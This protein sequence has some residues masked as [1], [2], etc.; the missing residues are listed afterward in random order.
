MRTPGTRTCGGCRFWSEMI[1]MVQDGEVVAMCL[2][3]GLMASRYTTQRQTCDAFAE[4]MH[5]AI[6]APPDH[7]EK[8]RATYEK[9]IRMN[10]S[11]LTRDDVELYADRLRPPHLA[12]LRVAFET[13]DDVSYQKIAERLHVPIGTVKSR[14]HR[15]RACLYTIKAKER[16]E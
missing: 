8:V 11:A 16:A 1:A 13:E 9:K 10:H 5:G 3:R 12:I 4:N 14:L 15:A 2:G 6:D 7:C